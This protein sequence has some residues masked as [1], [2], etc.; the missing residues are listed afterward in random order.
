MEVEI[1]ICGPVMG[2]MA[3]AGVSAGAASTGGGAAVLSAG[4]G[5]VSLPGGGAATGASWAE[6][7]VTV[8][9]RNAAMV[10]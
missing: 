10:R 9:S 5:M 4:A 6:A 3:G 8:K 2:G 7:P 1:R